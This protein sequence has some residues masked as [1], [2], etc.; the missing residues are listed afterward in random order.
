VFAS[1]FG[2]TAVSVGTT[3][4]N[5]L[6]D[7]IAPEPEPATAGL[8]SNF[9]AWQ[10]SPGA[11]GLPEIRIRYAP[12][13]WTLGPDV[14]VSSPAQ[15]PTEASAGIAAA[16][17]VNGDA[18][19]AW[20]QGTPGATWVMT[21]QLYQPPG[22]ISVSK[23]VRYENTPYPVLQ[24]GAPR[25]PWGPMSYSLSIDGTPVPGTSATAVRLPGIVANG[26]H[27]WQ[28][29]GVNPV[30]Q[31]TRLATGTVFVDTVPPSGKM[32]LY[33]SPSPKSSLHVYVSYADRPAAGASPRSAS[34]V[35]S[36]VVRWGD[37]TV[38]SLKPGTHRSFHAYRRAGRYVLSLQVTDRARNAIRQAIKVSV[39]SKPKRKAKHARKARHARAARHRRSR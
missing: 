38:A 35:A 7:A 2:D 6:A 18:A 25:E 21:D 3:Q 30:G 19:V 10:Q 27:R 29:G 24:W 39:K 20:L 31:P 5:T 32:T 13:G 14:V 28:V 12:D 4:V 15:G 1:G 33:G 8:Y 37:G 11:A 9:I 17:D 26:L 34:G 22:Q 23:S 16:G 36:V